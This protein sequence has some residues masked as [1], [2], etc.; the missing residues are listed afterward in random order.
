M[1]EVLAKHLI[2]AFVPVLTNHWAQNH[3]VFTQ[4]Q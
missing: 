4:S 2:P 1:F 3:L